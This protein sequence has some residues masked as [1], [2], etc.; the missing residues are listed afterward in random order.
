MKP[1]FQFYCV[2]H[3]R[4]LMNAMNKIVNNIGLW[5]IPL[6]VGLGLHTES[7][8][9]TLQ[10]SDEQV[11]QHSRWLLQ[12]PISVEFISL[13]Q[14]WLNVP[15]DLINKHVSVAVAQYLDC[16]ADNESECTPLPLWH[17]RRPAGNTKVLQ[18]ESLLTEQKE[19]CWL[20]LAHVD[21][22]WGVLRHPRVTESPTYKVNDSRKFEME[23]KNEKSYW[24]HETVRIVTNWSRTTGGLYTFRIL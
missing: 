20:L 12:I 4:K 13:E 11:L 16:V 10:L 24:F 14:I 8:I 5:T 15:F 3:L 23:K 1:F 7:G 6:L 19:H 22:S 18:V 21:I 17:C 9:C 2:Q